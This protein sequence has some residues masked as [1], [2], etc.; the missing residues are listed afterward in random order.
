MN[1]RPLIEPGDEDA[2]LDKVFRALGSVPR[3]SMLARLADGPAKVT[4]LAAMF[5]MTLP[6][7]SKNLRVLEQA[8]LVDRRIDGR[9]HCCTLA[10]APLAE[11]S[12]WLDHYRGFWDEALASLARYAEEGAEDHDEGPGG[13]I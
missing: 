4:D 5:E 6:A 1:A 2:R 13:G 12:R 10:G 11:L 3:R 7:V 9:V 8:G